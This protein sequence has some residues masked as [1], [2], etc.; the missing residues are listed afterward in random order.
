M[1]SQDT[2]ATS[3]RK[4]SFFEGLAIGLV[5]LVGFVITPLFYFWFLTPFMD[6]FVATPLGALTLVFASLSTSA[7]ACVGL[8]ISNRKLIE[9][10]RSRGLRGWL[11][12]VWDGA[13]V[14]LVTFFCAISILTASACWYTDAVGLRAERTLTAAGYSYEAGRYGGHYHIVFS[15]TDLLHAFC[16]FEKY[17]ACYIAFDF[18]ETDSGCAFCV[19]EGGKDRIPRGT[20]ILVT[21]KRSALGVH[22]DPIDFEPYET[23]D[24]ADPKLPYTWC[25]SAMTC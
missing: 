12:L 18:L 8:L 1:H 10:R 5:F 22:I 4:I 11:R 17:A 19:S 16:S 24:I 15:E 3:R 23:T 13:T 2:R 9:A 7:L 6:R 20:K 25:T 14:A 21:G